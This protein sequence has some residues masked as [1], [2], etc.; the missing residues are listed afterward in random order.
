MMVMAVCLNRGSVQTISVN[1]CLKRRTSVLS[2]FSS[3]LFRMGLGS[4]W[5]LLAS[6]A[7]SIKDSLILSFLIL[8]VN[9]SEE[10]SVIR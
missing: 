2:S 4:V 9:D 10:G 6:I 8:S 3:D 5:P 7:F 1:L